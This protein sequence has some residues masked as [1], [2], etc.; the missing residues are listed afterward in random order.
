MAEFIPG[1]R[2]ISDAE[3]QMGLG[4]ILAVEARTL[5]VLFLAT[6]ETRTYAKLTAPLTRVVF[7]IGDTINSHDGLTITVKE[8]SENH[9]LLSYSGIDANGVIHTVEEAELD[10]FIQ[11][12][13]PSERLFNGQIDKD[14]WF[15]LRYQTLFHKNRLAKSDLYG[16][17]GSRT[18]LIPHQLYIAHEVANRYAPR[19]LLADE[20]GLGKTI[21]AGLILH[22]QILTE[23]AKRVLIVVPETL[24]HQ[25]LVEMLRRFNLHFKIFDQQRCEDLMAG[26]EFENIF[27]SE[28]LVL[29]S[30]DFLVGNASVFEQCVFGDWDLMVVDEAHHL[31]WSADAVSDEYR[32]VERLGAVERER[33]MMLSAISHD[34]RTPLAALLALAAATILPA[35]TSTGETPS[36]F[37]SG[38][39]SGPCGRVVGHIE[40]EEE[41]LR[42]LPY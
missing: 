3:L 17:T 39:G 33:T 13:R 2:C 1:Q 37:E 31:L 34:L 41:C 32:M 9:G 35:C 23:R 8:V 4:T 11:L 28:Q 6:G 7:A 5:T 24:M 19:V 36:P 22:H 29:C 14:N 26:N 25:W 27:H 10:N 42:E 38:A 30:I 16:L 20:V 40:C 15:E 21:E 12:N 18:S